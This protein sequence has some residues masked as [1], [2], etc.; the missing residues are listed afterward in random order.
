MLHSTV[1]APTDLRT[2]RSGFT[3]LELVIAMAVTLILVSLAAPLYTMQ[4]KAVGTTAGRTDATRSATFA[5]DAMEQDIRN[6][7]VGVFDGQPLIARAAGD[8]ISFNANM[9]SSRTN[10]LVSVFYDPD[11]DSS[12]HGSLRKATSVLLP[13]SGDEYPSVRYNSDAET[14]SYFV[15]ADSTTSP[16]PGTDLYKLMRKV[17]HLPAEVIARNLVRVG[18]EPIL[19]YYRRGLSGALSLINP[20]SL[21]VY[22]QAARHGTAS[23][24][25][26]TTVIDSIAVVRVNL[27]S[28]YKDPRGGYVVDTLQR[29]IR[30]ANQGLLVRAQCGEP[31]IGPGVP[32]PQIQFVVPGVPW[33]RLQWPAS[34]DELTGERDVEMYAVYRR[35]FGDPDWGEPYANVPGS[36]L[37]TLTF[38][39]SGVVPGLQY[40]YAVSALDC[41]PAPSALSAPVSILV[42]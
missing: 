11:A 26:S 22:H 18:T 6:I 14:I 3:T 31:P 16:V 19:Q 12:A 27:I 24:T 23:D 41:T 32:V 10:D 29:S 13:N 38:Q 36:G 1:S 37:A 42:P 28:V 25:G 15:A 2:D 40:E 34:T 20:A 9:V 8:A 35:L 7:G 17:N 39:D 5:A 21:P 30:I 4:S 33:V